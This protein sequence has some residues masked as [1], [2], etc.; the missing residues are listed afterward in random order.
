VSEEIIE[1]GKKLN[2]DI[3]N[4]AADLTDLNSEETLAVL[5]YLQ[6]EILKLKEMQERVEPRR[7]SFENEGTGAGRES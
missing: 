7:S 6:S 2:E 3:E 4:G 1:L 5:H